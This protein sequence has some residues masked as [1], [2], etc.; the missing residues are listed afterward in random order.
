MIQDLLNTG[1]DINQQCR[2]EILDT[3]LA[4]AI[5]TGHS[6]IVRTLIDRGADPDLGKWT[7][8]PPLLEAGKQHN[9]DIVRILLV[10]GV[11][12]NMGLDRKP[13]GN[14]FGN[15]L[16]VVSYYGDTEIASQLLPKAKAEHVA[17]GLATAVREEQWATIDL[18]SEHVPELVLSHAA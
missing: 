11:D 17:K 3:P 18:Y 9:A 1:A 13:F 5:T 2:I 6:C 10:A 4:A 8:G 16:G 15:A 14:L 7:T 12:A